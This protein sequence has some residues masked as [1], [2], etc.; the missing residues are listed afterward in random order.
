M[1]IG[2]IIAGI[3][4]IK[5]DGL[6]SI[7]P[8]LIIAPVFFIYL[9]LFSRWKRLQPLKYYVTNKRLI[10]YDSNRN[11]ILNSYRFESFPKILLHEKLN[12]SGYIVIGEEEPT[13]VRGTGLSS[14]KYG[15][16]L[17][18]HSVVLENIP[19]VK[20]IVDLINS[21]IIQK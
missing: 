10:I 11:T 18:D 15:V 12:N 2:F 3:A 1:S 20:K 9:P 7:G 13:V 21:K 8:V 6:L 17:A 19:N 4:A 14:L 5:G 16:N